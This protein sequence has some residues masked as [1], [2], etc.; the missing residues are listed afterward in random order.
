MIRPLVLVVALLAGPALA[1]PGHGDGSGL[2]AGLAH[3]LGG[4]DHL[5]AMG[6]VGVWSALALPRA[7]I[8]AAP[9]A[10]V[11]AML[12][13]AGLALTG[14]PLPGV[15]F[16]IAA[17]VVALGVM[18][19]LRARFGLAIGVAVVGGFALFHGWAH[20]DE[21]AGGVAGYL[22][23]FAFATAAIHAAGVAVGL[24][25]AERRAATMVVGGGVAVAGVAMLAG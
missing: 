16:A 10:F 21:A 9:A 25:L 23:G 18:V 22:A 24:L 14:A 1:H 7:R 8:W 3:P 17:S 5:L 4:L 12:A 11:V 15:E 13:G 2:L 19:A 6:A 20:G